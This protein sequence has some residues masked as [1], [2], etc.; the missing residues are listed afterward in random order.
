MLS[1]QVGLRLSESTV[2]RR[3]E[4]AGA[5]AVCHQRALFKGEPTQGEA[6]WHPRAAA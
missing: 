6:F 3:T 5:D 2:E 4:A 1:K